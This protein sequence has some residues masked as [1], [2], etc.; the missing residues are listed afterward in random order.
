MR[1]EAVSLSGERPFFCAKRA[2][3][4]AAECRAKKEK[5]I[6]I[7][8]GIMSALQGLRDD[9]LKQ[10]EVRTRFTQGVYKTVDDVIM[11]ER[12]GNYEVGYQ[13]KPFTDGQTFRSYVYLTAPGEIIAEIPEDELAPIVSAIYAVFIVPG[14]SR[15][16]IIMGKRARQDSMLF[17]QDFQPTLLVERNPRQ[18]VH[19]IRKIQ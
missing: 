15:V 9:V 1:A 4:N 17:L 11:T 5:K 12:V 18:K 19:D 6:E 7:D 3:M 2:T 14:Q 13:I 8:I 16:E 10:G